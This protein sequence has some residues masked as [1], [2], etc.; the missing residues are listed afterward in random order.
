MV[1]T[2]MISV[3]YCIRLQGLCFM[4][5]GERVFIFVEEEYACTYKYQHYREYLGL[6]GMHEAPVVLVVYTDQFYEEAL[7]A[8]EYEVGAKHL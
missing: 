2:N 5:C 6:R 7:Y 1:A 4:C 3:M 8:Y